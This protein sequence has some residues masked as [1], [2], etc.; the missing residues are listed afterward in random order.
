MSTSTPCT[1]TS[2]SVLGS[3]P[4]QLPL[5]SADTQDDEY[6]VDYFK[7]FDFVMNALDNL[8]ASASIQLYGA[9]PSSLSVLLY[10]DARR[11]VNKMCLAANIPLLES[12][13]SGYVGQVQPI[14]RETTECFDCTGACRSPSVTRDAMRGRAASLAPLDRFLKVSS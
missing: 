14:K 11:H 13:T 6:N 1:A 8:G 5:T 3:L 7:S 4:L 2:R 12:G 9:I 10:S